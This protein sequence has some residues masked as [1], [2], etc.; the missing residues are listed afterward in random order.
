[1]STVCYLERE[2]APWVENP[3]VVNFVVP[4]MPGPERGRGGT[5]VADLAR[6]T[7]GELVV[8]TDTKH[9]LH[10]WGT[11]RK[12]LMACRPHRPIRRP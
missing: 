8:A 10:G 6:S 9:L 4:P 7:S 2:D 5:R 12:N 1:M 11:G 3:A